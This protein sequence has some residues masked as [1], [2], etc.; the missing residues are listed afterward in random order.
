MDMLSP[1]RSSGGGVE[2]SLQL[3]DPVEDLLTFSHPAFDLAT[4]MHDG[5]VVTSAKLLADVG[6]RKIRHV[7]GDVH[8]DL[9]S[10]NERPSTAATDDVLDVEAEH[11]CGQFNDAFSGDWLFLVVGDEVAEYE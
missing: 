7:S 11:L 5:G 1:A 8:G 3:S 9:A 4:G 2:S 10:I 6:K